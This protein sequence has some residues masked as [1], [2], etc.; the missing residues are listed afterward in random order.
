[1]VY[2]GEHYFVDVLAGVGY[3][4][5]ATAAVTLFVRW[6]SRPTS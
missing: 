3:A 6:R 5:A 1:V 2:L 4:L